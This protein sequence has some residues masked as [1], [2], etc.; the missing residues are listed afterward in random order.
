MGVPVDRRSFLGRY[1]M[2][3]DTDLPRSVHDIG[4]L[5]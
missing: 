5:M 4:D 1:E 3:E 2:D